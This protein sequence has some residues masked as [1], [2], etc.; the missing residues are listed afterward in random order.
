MTDRPTRQRRRVGAIVVGLLTVVLGACSEP[1]Q[2]EYTAQE[3]ENF[4]AACTVPV[5]DSILQGRLCQCV[6]E[7]AQTQITYERFAEIDAA[8]VA[9]PL[10]DL[11][12]ELTEIVAQCVID[13]ADL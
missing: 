1:I 10:A 11:P 3:S 5:E 4:F 13:E 8:L 2:T 9:D 7:R 12:P 6:F